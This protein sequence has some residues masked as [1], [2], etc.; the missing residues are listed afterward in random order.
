MRDGWHQGMNRLGNRVC[1][2]EGLPTTVHV[3][4][5]RR[6]D[7][8]ILTLLHYVPT[9]KAADQDVIEHPSSFAGERLK[10]HR[11][12]KVKT[13]RLFGGAEL[14][15]FEAGCYALPVAKGRLLVEVPG[16]FAG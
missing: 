1:F 14:E 13:V 16:Y 9:R 12:E 7:D 10:F 5:R 3:F 11:P 4:P 2:G 6:G 8:L 15:R